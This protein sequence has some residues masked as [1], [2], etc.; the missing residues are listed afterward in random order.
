MKKPPPPQ[1]EFRTAKPVRVPML[2]TELP[3]TPRPTVPEPLPASTTTSLADVKAILLHRIAHPLPPATNGETAPAPPPWMLSVPTGDWFTWSQEKQDQ[4]VKMMYETGCS[5]PAAC[6]LSGVHP[7]QAWEWKRKAKQE[8]ESGERYDDTRFY[9]Q[10]HLA[11]EIAVNRIE[12]RGTTIIS[13]TP[14][15]HAQAWLMKN[16]PNLRNRWK[17]PKQKVEVGASAEIT[18]RHEIARRAAELPQDQLVSEAERFGT[19]L[20]MF[21]NEDGAFEPR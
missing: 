4:I 17:D 12:V 16:H 11:T 20:D 7:N 2:L 21:E 19:L 13:N 15:W 1:P 6:R 9:H 18:V 5:L 8:I 10:F 14:D 3:E